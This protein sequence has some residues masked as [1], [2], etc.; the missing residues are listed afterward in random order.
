MG[1]IH[2][3]TF[4]HVVNIAGFGEWRRAKEEEGV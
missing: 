3:V 1:K 4:I 2:L